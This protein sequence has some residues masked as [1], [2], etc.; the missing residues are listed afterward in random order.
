MCGRY[1]LAKPAKT[2]KEYFAPVTIK[3][4]HTE[5][6]NIAPGQDSPVITLENNQRELRLMRWG[7]IPSWLK[8]FNP[9]KTLINARS[10]TIHQKPA[11]RNSFK[12]HRCLVPANGFIEWEI[13]EKEKEPHYIF[14]KPKNIFAFAGIWTKWNKGHK[15]IYSYSILTTQANTRLA[16]IHDRMPVILEPKNYKLWL[17]PLAD[18]KLLC[19]MLHPFSAKK[20]EAYK[21]SKE[22]NLYKNDHNDLL[23][24]LKFN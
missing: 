15:S 8:D 6:Y 1:T 17:D 23:Q 5:R 9:A 13:A 16:L 19:N 14:L 11:F 18:N 21:I 10:E 20:T 12:T 3:C 7:F 2:I 4:A 24:P 22:I